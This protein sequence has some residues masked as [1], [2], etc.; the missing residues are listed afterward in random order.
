[1]SFTGPLSALCNDALDDLI[2]QLCSHFQCV[3]ISM[4]DSML[5]RLGHHL[6]WEW[7]REALMHIGPVQQV[8][9]H[10]WIQ[11]WVYLVPGPN[12]L[13]HR[14]GQH[15]IFFISSH[16]YQVNN[17][18]FRSYMLGYCYIWFHWWVLLIVLKWNKV[19]I[20]P[21]WNRTFQQGIVLDHCAAKTCANDIILTAHW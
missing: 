16:W 10:I 1:M 20:I 18:I 8:F 13:W 17:Q 4:L 21:T 19:R 7:I 11:H 3:G 15:S 9:Q 14:D 6:P 12:S 5:R 2:S